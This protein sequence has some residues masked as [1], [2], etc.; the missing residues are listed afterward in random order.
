MPH[1]QVH[2]ELDCSFN[3]EIQAKKIEKLMVE[4]VDLKVP[5]KVDCEIG[6][7][8]GEIK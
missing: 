7:N 3:S 6:Q 2:D 4:C 1:I 5:V 8:W